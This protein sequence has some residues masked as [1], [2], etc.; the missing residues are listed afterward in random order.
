M[1]NATSNLINMLSDDR[2]ENT[3]I[4]ADEEALLLEQINNPSMDEVPE[5]DEARIERI[6][7]DRM[8]V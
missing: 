8:Y 1:E 7:N 6:F 3:L 4:F 2:S 5:T